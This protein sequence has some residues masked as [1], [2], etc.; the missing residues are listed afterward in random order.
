[1]SPGS[2]DSRPGLVVR[3]KSRYLRDDLVPFAVGTAVDQGGRLALNLVAASVLGPATF[4]TWVILSMV[5]QYSNFASLGVPQGTG[6]EVP[7]LLGARR[8]EAAARVEDVSTAAT[9]SIAAAVALACIAVPMLVIDPSPSGLGSPSFVLLAIVVGFQQ[10]I[11]LEQVLFR[12]RLRF[13]AAAVQLG[14]QGLVALAA[15]ALM[16]RAGAGIDSLLAA[17]VAVA[18]VAVALVSHTLA[19][20]PRP[21]WNWSLTKELISIGAPMLLAG[22][23][24]VAI[25][26]IDRW[27]V[28]I[29][30]G[31]EAVGIYGLVGVVVS[32]LILLPNLVSQQHLPRMAFAHGEGVTGSG[33]QAMAHEQ[34]VMAGGL[35]VPAAIAGGIAVMVGIPL[36]LPDYQDAVVPI[37]IVLV[38]VSVYSFSSG[39]GN[40]HVLLDERQRYVVIQVAALFMN[41]S[42]ALVLIAL[43]FGLIGVATAS[44]VGLVAYG[45]M[46]RASANRISVMRV[47]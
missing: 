20:V 1:L 31:Q 23:L 47:N 16:L 43:G 41:V 30:F 4:G 36:L 44:T 9:I 21:K 26:T 13:R 7:R 24:V 45:L 17:R 32:S 3:V 40:L 42:V 18:L 25:V 39:Y 15:G 27:I 19:R 5:I 28:L 38:G 46:L 37:E 6:R 34:G 29:A 12:S 22:A 33:L 35:V 11:G 8:P 10:L 14:A 2:I